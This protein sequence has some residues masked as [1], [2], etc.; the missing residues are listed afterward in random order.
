MLAAMAKIERL[1]CCGLAGRMGQAL[2]D[3]GL[4][5]ARVD[6]SSEYPMRDFGEG[7]RGYCRRDYLSIA[8]Y[9]TD[10]GRD[11]LASGRS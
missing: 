10:A 5:V 7:R 3:R 8:Y 4:A 6:R 1:G 2:V 9:L 11:V